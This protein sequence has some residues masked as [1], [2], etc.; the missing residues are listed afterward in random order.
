MELREGFG[1]IAALQQERLA[2]DDLSQ[3]GLQIARFACKNE[4]RIAAKLLFGGGKRLRVPVNGH[5]QPFMAPPAIR[6]PVRRHVMQIGRDTSEL[7]YLMSSS[8]AVF[9]L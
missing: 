7:Q 9:C 2:S 3:F 4:R 1:A 5:L 6:R 8:Y